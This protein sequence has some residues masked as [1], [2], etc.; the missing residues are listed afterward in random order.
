MQPVS[1]SNP[2]TQCASVCV[3]GG[4]VPCVCVCVF[5]RVCGGGD[6]LHFVPS[7]LTKLLSDIDSVMRERG[8]EIEVETD[9]EK[10]R[11]GGRVG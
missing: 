2:P 8:R 6:G 1:I 9:G 3:C 5:M 4:M 11:E 7:R 10:E